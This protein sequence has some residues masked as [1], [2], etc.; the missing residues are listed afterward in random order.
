MFFDFS[1]PWV[2]SRLNSSDAF[3]TGAPRLG[4]YVPGGVRPQEAPTANGINFDHVYKG[5]GARYRHHKITISLCNLW[6]DILRQS[7]ILFPS[8]FYPIVL[9]SVDEFYLNQLFII[10]LS[11]LKK[12]YQFL[13]FHLFLSVSTL[14]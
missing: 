3:L 12:I 1:L 9:A 2:V 7:D 4:Y 5:V 8:N 10:I 6:G 14:I 13:L 11:F